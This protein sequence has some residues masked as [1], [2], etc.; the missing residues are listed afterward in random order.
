[1]EKVNAMPLGGRMLPRLNPRDKKRRSVGCSF[2]EQGEFGYICLFGAD[3]LIDCYGSLLFDGMECNRFDFM[4]MCSECP[5][6]RGIPRPRDIR[7]FSM[8]QPGFIAEMKEDCIEHDKP[9]CFVYFISDGEFIKIGKAADPQKRLG[10]LQ[11]A[12]ARKLELLYVVPCKGD[13]AARDVE[14]YLH[15]V[16]REY[17]R[18]G[19]WFD[20]LR[21]LDRKG[22]DGY[23]PACNYCEERG[24]SKRCAG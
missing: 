4:E 21:L 10:E 16:Y 18:E 11:T 1:M 6:C 7:S 3:Q 20:I 9:K 22:F 5:Y 12:N 17:A 8:F 23:W 15:R 2:K 24:G 19:E 14:A 13:A